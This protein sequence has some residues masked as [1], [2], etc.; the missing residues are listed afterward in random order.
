MGLLLFFV[1]LIS[2]DTTIMKKILIIIFACFSFNLISQNI[3]YNIIEIP[4]STLLDNTTKVALY[5]GQVAF[6]DGTSDGSVKLWNGS[7]T[8]IIDSEVWGYG[9]ISIYNGNIAYQKSAGANQGIRVYYWNGS[10]STNISGNK[11]AGWH[12]LYD[13]TVLLSGSIDGNHELYLWENNNTTQ[14]T[15][16]NNTC[17][18]IPTINGNQY[19]WVECG[20]LQFFNGDT[21]VFINTESVAPEGSVN[22]GYVNPII[23]T[24]NGQIAFSASDGHD[25]EIFFWNGDSIIQIT[26][27]DSID[28]SP[29]LYDGGIAWVNG[30]STDREIFFWNGNF[31]V[32]VTNNNIPDMNPSLFAG[33]IAWN[34]GAGWQGTGKVYYA[35]QSL[36]N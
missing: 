10:S 24:F 14:I 17:S 20:V 8:T 4:N 32:Q 30:S 36:T 6:Y 15:D 21:T 33:N 25:K 7:T 31:T 22:R 19:A 1:H 28:D 29:S 13:G 34:G 5:D 35:T 27:N 23:S 11:F 9:N 18:P 26:D 12:S 3:S 16:N 2:I